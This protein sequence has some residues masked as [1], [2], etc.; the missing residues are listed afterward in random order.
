M[1]RLHE[2]D[3]YNITDMGVNKV[4]CSWMQILSKG[5]KARFHSPCPISKSSLP[6]N[7]IFRVIFGN[8]LL[9]PYLMG[10]SLVTKRFDANKDHDPRRGYLLFQLTS[11]KSKKIHVLGRFISYPRSQVV[12]ENG[13]LSGWKGC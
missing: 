6:L 12:D 1:R 7:V 10:I 13:C 8:I 4:G 11:K 5:F 3:E 9:H 2:R